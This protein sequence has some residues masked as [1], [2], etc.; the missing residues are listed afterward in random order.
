MINLHKQ[1]RTLFASACCPSQIAQPTCRSLTGCYSPAAVPVFS[2]SATRTPAHTQLTLPVLIGD[3]DPVHAQRTW[4]CPAPFL[5]WPADFIAG[6]TRELL[7][8]R[9][10]FWGKSRAAHCR[11]L[12]SSEL[13]RHTVGVLRHGRYQSVE[14]RSIAPEERS[15]TSQRSSLCFLHG[16]N[17]GEAIGGKAWSIGSRASFYAGMPPILG[18][19]SSNCFSSVISFASGRVR[20]ER[21][22]TTVSPAER[23]IN[24]RFVAA[25]RMDGAAGVA[26]LSPLVQALAPRTVR[27]PKPQPH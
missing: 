9:R 10:C 26:L 24:G 18:G 27:G 14:E 13:F 12:L 4:F 15:L 16:R 1:E 17:G 7:R 20:L 8:R 2:K 11:F 25:S 21:E 6:S 19:L 23:G 5:P 3:H 22:T